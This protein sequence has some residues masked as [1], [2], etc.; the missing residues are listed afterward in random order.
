MENWNSASAEAK[1][2][3]DPST[4]NEDDPKILPGEVTSR[5][6]TKGQLEHLGL[7]QPKVTWRRRF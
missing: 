7:G 5:L 1:A 6:M 4:L 3:A 2:A